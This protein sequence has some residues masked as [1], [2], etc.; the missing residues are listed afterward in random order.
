MTTAKFNYEEP[1]VE[2]Y[3]VE[4]EQGFLVSDGSIND[5]EPGDEW[6]PAE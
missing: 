1:R 6:A 4:V 3:E 5:M 2:F